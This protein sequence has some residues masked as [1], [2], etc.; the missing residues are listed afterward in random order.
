MYRAVIT[1]QENTL[2]RTVTAVDTAALLLVMSACG[3]AAPDADLTPSSPTTLRI[4]NSFTVAGVD[5]AAAGAQ[6]CWEFGYCE[7]PMRLDAEGRLEPW[8]LE[9]LDPVDDLTWRLALRDGITFQNGSPLDAAALAASMQ[10]QI[11]EF[12]GLAPIL[13]GATAEVTG[14]R[15]VTLRTAAPVAIVPELLAERTMFPIYDV[16]A[17]AAAGADL[18]GAGVFTAPYAVS[19]LDDQRLTL[20]AYPGYWV[21]PPALPGV[22][23][24]FVSDEQARL[25]A[26]ENGEADM[27]LYP[28]SG[29]Q[30][31]LAG[32]D[33]IALRRQPVAQEALRLAPNVGE[34]L[35]SE[36]A[37]RRAVALGV[38]YRALAE[39][40]MGGLYDT[41]ESMYPSALEYAQPTQRTD[42]AE[43]GRVL[44]AAGWTPGADGVRTRG[45]QQLRLTL[46]T[47]PQQPD[48]A[49]MAVA[50]QAQLA[51]VGIGVEIRQV[52]DI[53]ATIADPP[54]WDLALIFNTTFSF[55]SGDSVT[56]LRRY[57]YSTS[58]DNAGRYGVADPELDAVIDALQRTF[59]VAER[60]RLLERAQQIVMVEQ[61]YLMVAGV[62]P[63][64]ILV[65]RAWAGFEVP[66]DRRLITYETA[67]TG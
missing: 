26:L 56:P 47:Y 60:S 66:A 58:Q 11:D 38:D 29:V 9:V 44:D 54:Q 22:E 62:K 31:V 49:T 53:N 30:D 65:D 24:R 18:V 12:P 8:L 2:K 67:P 41:A 20:Q 4:L 16:A 14:P 35:T 17:V 23:V 48:T 33:D 51:P 37:V 55:F 61:N 50:I 32:R 43:A 34:G 7:H 36:L 46:L 52:D 21:G 19:G 6:W 27:V 40:V 5:P 28:P 57:L 42:P 45:G 39:E 10:R 25:V 13:L 1:E 59:D 3:G 64:P 63:F 15:E